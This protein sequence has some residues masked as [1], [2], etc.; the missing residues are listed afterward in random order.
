MTEFRTKGKGKERKVYPVKKRQPFG[1]TR[2]LAY[3]EVQALRE[4]GKRARLIETNSRLEL[5][6]PYE[7]ALPGTAASSTSSIEEPAN[8]VT[9]ESGAKHETVEHTPHIGTISREKDQALKLI[10]LLNEDGKLQMTNEQL[11]D[12]FIDAKISVNDGQMRYIS[13]D[14]SHVMMVE[15][16]L[17]TSLP[18]GF[19]HIEQGEDKRFT[20][21][22]GV[23]PAAARFNMPKLNFEANSWKAQ[24]DG[25]NLVKLMGFLRKPSND[26]PFSPTVTFR[27][28]GNKVLIT[29]FN[30]KEA[31]RERQLRDSHSPDKNTVTILE[32]SAQPSKSTNNVNDDAWQTANFDREMLGNMFKTMMARRRVKTDNGMAIS[33]DLKADY[34]LSAVIRRTGPNNERIEAHGLI[35]PRME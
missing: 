16:V 31:G 5:Y 14:P 18:N 20:L 10:G 32:F 3:D 7:S 26:D 8:P 25:S 35:A 22:S 13:V 24:I 17:P 21:E 30:E 19:Y 11:R 33:L 6:A 2:K 1:V 4:Q 27:M 28:K 23:D 12:F 34:P 15:E 29:G 9:E